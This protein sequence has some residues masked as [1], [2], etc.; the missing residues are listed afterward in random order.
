MDGYVRKEARSR[1]AMTRWR[2]KCMWVPDI[3]C[4]YINDI[5]MFNDEAKARCSK[6]NLMSIIVAELAIRL[7]DS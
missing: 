5:Y 4:T 7:L 6:H 2:G 1:A 3:P